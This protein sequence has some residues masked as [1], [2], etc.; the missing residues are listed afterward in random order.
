MLYNLFERITREV[1]SLKSEWRIVDSD[2][3]LEQ[4]LSKKFGVSPFLARLLSK[5]VK[6]IQEAEELL[7]PER[8]KLGNPYDMFGMH[9]VVRELIKIREKKEP[10]VIYGD[11]DVD[12]V[13]GTALYYLLLK[14][15]GWN[16]EY[17]I[18]SRLEEGYGLSKESIKK[19]S[20]E[21][22][23]NF[24]T[25][26]CGITSIDEV[27][28]ANDLGCKIIITDHHEPK[29]VLPEATAIVNPKCPQDTYSFKSFSG[30]GVAYKVVE[31]L[32][33]YLQTDDDL[34]NYLD[35]VALG[36]IAD[37][38]PLMGENRYFVYK[39][40]QLLSL[41]N[42]VGLSALMEA[43]NVDFENIKAHDV[44]FRIAPKINAV[45]RIDNAVTA[46]QL[47]IEEDSKEAAKLA[48]E[49]VRKNQERQFIENQIYQEAMASL[50]NLEI[51][52][53]KALVIDHKNW[54]PGVIGIVASRILSIYHKPTFM[55]S[56]DGEMA[57]GSA[58]SIDN[59][60]IIDVLSMAKDLLEEFGGHKMA[61]GF[62]LRTEMIGAF[63]ERIN[64][65][66]ADYDSELLKSELLIDDEIALEDINEEFV[67]GI[68]RLKPF[69]NGN[70]EPVFLIRD[71]RIEQLRPVGKSSFK[72]LL[73]SKE[74]RME[75]VGF[76]LLESTNAFRFSP[77]YKTADVVANIWINSWNDRKRYQ[78][79]IIDLD[80]KDNL[81][82]H[83][84]HF[85]EI[86]IESII[87]QNSFVIGSAD[88]IE[89]MIIEMSKKV[90]N[91]VI[92]LPTNSMLA[93]L[94][95]SVKSSL[96]NFKLGYVDALHPPSDEMD[97]VFTNALSLG[98][99]KNSPNLIIC[100]P[101]MMIHSFAFD[102]MLYNV[103]RLNPKTLVFFSSFVNRE[104][105]DKII[106]DFNCKVV[107]IFQKQN[108]GII[109]DRNVK[110]KTEMIIDLI[111]SKMKTAVIFSN[112]QS[113]KSFYS[114]LCKIYPGMCSNQEIT[115]Y[116][117]VKNVFLKYSKVNLLLVNGMNI[118]KMEFDRIVYYDFPRNHMEFLKPPA[119][120]KERFITLHIAF[121][122]E[123]FEQNL[124]DLDEIFPSPYRV[125]ESAK[126]IHKFENEDPI[127]VLVRS[128]IAS[129]RSIARIYLSILSEISAFDG[130]KITRIPSLN[131]IEKSSREREG[132]ME[133]LNLRFLERD[134]MN[135]HVRNIAKI[136]QKPF[137][138]HEKSGH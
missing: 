27:C 61:A 57:R 37:I 71:L 89:K 18:P 110:N 115:V 79:N 54:H 99:I 51:D 38:V 80:V 76:G 73:R 135:S 100:E 78:L 13:T 26:D 124:R 56:I 50:D 116:N 84:H 58:R 15:W 39:G 94:F 32:K 63:K 69:G 114:K 88:V 62:S 9:D 67:N 91:L 75:G 52:K 22:K 122:Y 43:S 70:A 96:L 24:L 90:R 120:L 82:R 77:G 48:D 108:V 98:R 23:K 2:K 47:I 132:K 102:E 53:L 20:D 44:G 11:Y 113:L 12:G 35:I 36:T 125:I 105:E 92:V 3:D 119:I 133:R 127:D 93:D 30:V 25:V 72:V 46:L 103:E 134:L 8:I 7:F 19:F 1:F 107:K 83:D 68:E 109:D 45:G 97:I 112:A 101:Q 118:P 81:V 55:I 138:I 131:E 34:E 117:G 137:E 136:F 17:H 59:V 129:S 28:Y 65:I 16:V 111:E 64:E 95:N 128:E 123:D 87:N 29:D 49:L 5:R 42:R 14:K 33:E 130:K 126:S 106:R 6:N 74:S 85:D 60:N 4:I 40:I 21:G 121:G 41:K 31:A 86:E 66:M 104:E 10:L